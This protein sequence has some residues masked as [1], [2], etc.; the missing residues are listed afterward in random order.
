MVYEA[1]TVTPWQSS[2]SA[3]SHTRKSSVIFDK[4]KLFK[5]A[6]LPQFDPLAHGCLDLL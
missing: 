3:L 4:K 6:A 5:M 1:H 2:Q